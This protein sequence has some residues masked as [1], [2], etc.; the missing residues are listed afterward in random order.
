MLNEEKL[1]NFAHIAPTDLLHMVSSRPVHLVLA[2]L[3]EE[4]Q[5]YVDFYLEEKRRNPRTTIILDNSAFERFKQGRPMYPSDKLIEMG[6]HIHA[7]YIV[8]SDYPGE[9][10][11]KTIAAA[12]ELAPQFK[13]AGFGTFFVPQSR[14]GELEDVIQGFAWAAEHPDLIDYIGISILTAPNAYGVEKDNKLQRFVARLNLLYRLQA[15]GIL[16]RAVGGGQRFHMLGMVD[17]PNEV[18]YTT[19]FHKYISTWDSSAAVWAGVNDIK[20]DHSPTGLINGKFE[21]EVDFSYRASLTPEQMRTIVYNMNYID[22]L[23]SGGV[24]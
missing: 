15:H 19:P 9:R 20:F 13:A 6:R 5:Q 23:C 10:G 12:K 3:V 21:K 17:G 1:I 18:L 7:D 11:I 16:D 2:H 4:D 14:I 8:M 22:G 24:C